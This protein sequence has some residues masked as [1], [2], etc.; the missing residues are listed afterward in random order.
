MSDKSFL[1]TE[2][3]SS[4]EE[5]GASVS[6]TQPPPNLGDAFY[7]SGGSRY[8]DDEEE[9]GGPQ[10]PNVGISRENSLEDGT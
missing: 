6:E 8:G 7:A 3:P 2:A 10:D 9:E 5:A 4:G 1:S